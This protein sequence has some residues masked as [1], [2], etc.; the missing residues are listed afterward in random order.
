VPVELFRNAEEIVLA[1]G[2]EAWET[3][4]VAVLLMRQVQRQARQPGVRSVAFR[5]RALGASS[6]HVSVS[7]PRASTRDPVGTGSE[8]AAHPPSRP[9]SR[10]TIRT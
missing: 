4:L 3:Y 10:S 8:S 7:G 5:L 6:E 1:K 2:L 9:R